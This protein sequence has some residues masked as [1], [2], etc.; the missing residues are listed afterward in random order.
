MLKSDGQKLFAE[1]AFR[2][3]GV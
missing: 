3:I 1:H 2:A